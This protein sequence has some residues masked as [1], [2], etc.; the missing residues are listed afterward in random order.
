MPDETEGL[1]LTEVI[2]EHDDLVFR[3]I[4]IE[5][6]ANPL[7][8]SMRALTDLLRKERELVFG[9]NSTCLTK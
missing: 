5:P 3:Q 6:T 4:I 1:S 8:V 9:G 7:V 2:Q